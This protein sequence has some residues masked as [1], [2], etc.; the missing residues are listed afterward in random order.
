MSGKKNTLVDFFIVGAQKSGTRALASFLKQSPEVGLSKAGRPEPRYFDTLNVKIEN[1]DYSRYHAHFTHDSLSRITG[2]STPS[3]IFYPQAIPAIHR[4]N[5]DAKIICI[6]RDPTERAY[7]QWNMQVGMG[8]ESRS[9]IEAL[10][11]E[12]TYCRKNELHRNYSYVRR[13]LYHRQI[14]HVF[15]VFPRDQCLILR[16]EELRHNHYKTMNDVFRFLNVKQVE[17]PAQEIVHSRRYPPPPASADRAL[18][19]FFRKDIEDLE[20]LLGWDCSAWK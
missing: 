2:D 7:S 10:K 12:A 20:K 9:F 3:Y 1:P 16:N 5:P 14:L 4:Y 17:I 8:K 15:D 6:L 11:N 19:R 13:G 18:K